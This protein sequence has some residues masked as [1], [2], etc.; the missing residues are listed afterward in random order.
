[1]SKQHPTDVHYRDVK[2][3]MEPYAPFTP[4]FQKTLQG[5]CVAKGIGMRNRG[6]GTINMKETIPEGSTIYKAF[7]YWAVLRLDFQAVNARG[8]CNGVPITGESIASSI[9]PSC[10]N[11]GSMDVFRAD[12]TGIATD[13]LNILTGFPSGDT[14]S[15]SPLVKA[16]FPLLEGASLILIFTNPNSMLKNIIIHDGGVTFCNHTVSTTF[17]NFQIAESPEAKTF[18]IVAGSQATSPGHQAICNNVVV[19]GPTAN[20]RSSNAFNGQDGI[21][22]GIDPSTGLWDTLEVDVSPVVHPGDRS[23]LTAVAA[24]HAEE[25]R[26]TYI[27]QAFSVNVSPCPMLQSIL[28]IEQALTDVLQETIE[29]GDMQAIENTLKLVIQKEILFDSL[30]EEYNDGS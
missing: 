15:S 4:S 10:G 19:A 30:L 21:N 13:G 24:S 22:A 23:V 25:N 18:Y 5:D 16:T 28:H 2:S 1:M 14:D 7:L 9:A 26:L 27:A 11:A 6:F 29:S 20:L 8:V 17:S 12:V 3:I